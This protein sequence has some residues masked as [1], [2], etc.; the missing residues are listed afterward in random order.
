MNVFLDLQ[1]IEAITEIVKEAQ[2]TEEQAYGGYDNDDYI[3]DAIDQDD[4]DEA[5]YPDEWG[6]YP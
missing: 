6:Q 1:T 3:D 4:L 5:S 2:S